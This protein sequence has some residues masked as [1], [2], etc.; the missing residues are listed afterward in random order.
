M[1]QKV[2]AVIGCGRIANAAH[3]PAFEK[4]DG[5]RIKY[6]C[7]LIEERL[8]PPQKNTARWKMLSPTIT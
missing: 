1:K 6:A 4:I 2:I 3:F 5:I 7:D 8:R